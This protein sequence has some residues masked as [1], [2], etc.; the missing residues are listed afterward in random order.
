M[1][2]PVPRTSQHLVP[3]TALAQGELW[4]STYSTEGRA[5]TDPSTFQ[6]RRAQQLSHLQSDE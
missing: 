6:P 1:L 5:G 2:V 3:S 4:E